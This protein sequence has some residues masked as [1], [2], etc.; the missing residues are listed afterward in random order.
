MEHL[1]I[2]SGVIKNQF[3]LMNFRQ[4]IQIPGKD[5]ANN[6]SKTNIVMP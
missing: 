2:M 6:D 5:G 4:E 1:F 3:I